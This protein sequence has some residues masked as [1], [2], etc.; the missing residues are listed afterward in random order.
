MCACGK[1]L[2]EECVSETVVD[3]NG[4][5]TMCSGCVVYYCSSV[6]NILCF[7]YFL[8][9]NFKKIHV[10]NSFV[11]TLKSAAMCSDSKSV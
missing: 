7:N 2:R 11:I 10:Y 5:L 6:N 1:W 8:F 3:A 9:L 4:K